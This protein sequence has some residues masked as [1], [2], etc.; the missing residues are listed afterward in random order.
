MIQE[1]LT[2]TMLNRIRRKRFGE[3][4][5]GEGLINHE[6][7][8]EALDLQKNSGEFL[9]SI[10]L[11][12]GY[13]TEAD[14]VKTL[15]V[16]H[17]LPFLRPSLYDLDRR[18][19]QK[20][21]PDFLHLNKVLPVDQI[22]NLLLLVVTDIP[23]EEVLVEIQEICQSNLAIYIASIHEVD[24]TLREVAPLSEEE[25]EAIRRLRKSE[26]T[27]SNSEMADKVSMD[28]VSFG[29]DT[30]TAKETVYTMDTSWESIFDEADGN[31][32]GDA[33]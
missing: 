5:V 22:G 19:I 20:F 32:K 7:L 16:Q 21:R 18:L 33:D 14:I 9:G 25:E 15:S 6:Q 10:L 4:I 11:D 23:N 13:I 26:M 17:Q 30:E 1:Y 3:I 27:F 2:M 8:Q 24:Q 28:T 29:S 12:L 31:V